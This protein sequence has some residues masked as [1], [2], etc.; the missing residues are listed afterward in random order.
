MK[1]SSALLLVGLIAVAT[2]REAP[3]HPRSGLDP[4]SFDVSVRPQDDL[5]QFV[6][7]RWL[8]TTEIPSDR[9]AYGAFTE[10]TE[11]AE[12]D[13][14]AIIEEGVAS[15]PRRRSLK[16]LIADLYTSAMDEARIDALGAAP[17]SPVL[18]RI[19]RIRSTSDLSAM[20]GYLGF[21]GTGGPFA[22]NVVTD[23]ADVNRLVVQLTQGGTLLPTPA[24]CS[25]PVDSTATIG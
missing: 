16:Q 19:D 1:L 8:A 24:T 12:T 18:E 3:P 20:A 13:L 10:L 23:A 22:A 17:A 5:Y 7:G 25:A 14:R 6:N 2:I 21:I 9:V 11:K 4:A 15:H